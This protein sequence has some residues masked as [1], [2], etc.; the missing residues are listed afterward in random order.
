VSEAAGTIGPMTHNVRAR[1]T[2]HVL[3]SLHD[4]W[5]SVG[6][7]RAVQDE[8]WHDLQPLAELRHPVLAKCCEQFGSDPSHDL[9]RDR[10]A[11]SGSLSLA[12]VRIQQWRA[13]VWTDP[14]THVRWILA[15]GRAKGDHQDRDDF[16]EQLSAHV[17]RTGGDDLLPTAVDRRLL[18]RET[19]AWVLTRLELKVQA[20]AGCLLREAMAHSSARALIAHPTKK[21]IREEPV[22]LTTAILTWTAHHEPDFDYEDLVVE[23]TDTDYSSPKLLATVQERLLISLAPPTQD[24]DIAGEIYAAMEEH[25]HSRTRIHELEEAEAREEL[26]PPFLGAVS[27]YTHKRH[28]TSAVVNANAV[29]ALCGVFFVPMRDPQDLATCPRCETALSEI[30]N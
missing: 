30:P 3:R 28:I 15:V 23:F 5:E 17:S 24:W 19:M 8:R 6:Q 1:P 26:L 12:E 2:L 18:E 13:G 29:R 11:S 10:I 4:G 25:G 16:Y 20:I 14:D 22:P 7:Q 27:H 21:N 9:Y